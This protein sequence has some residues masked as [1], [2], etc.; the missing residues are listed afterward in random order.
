MKQLHFRYTFNPKPYRDLNEDQN[1]S[2]LE[3]HMFVNGNRDGTIKGRTVAGGNKQRDFIN[4]E[5]YISPTVSTEAV[6][7]SCIIDTED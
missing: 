4:K 6:M 1:N 5:D 2:I 7:L 3:S